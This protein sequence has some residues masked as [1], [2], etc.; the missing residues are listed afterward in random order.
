M[1]DFISVPVDQLS[2]ARDAF[3]VILKQILKKLAEAAVIANEP[4]NTAA[5][6]VSIKQVS[7]KVL[8][9]VLVNLFNS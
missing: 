9:Y 2:T 7:I 6:N 3:R 4:S 1:N 5:P 8:L